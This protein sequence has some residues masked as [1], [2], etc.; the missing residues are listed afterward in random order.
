[1][2]KGG[3]QVMTTGGAEAIALPVRSCVYALVPASQRS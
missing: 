1:M 2:R 3:A